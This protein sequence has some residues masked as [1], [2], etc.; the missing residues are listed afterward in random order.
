MRVDG[1]PLQH[2]VDAFTARVRA[3]QSS[4]LGAFREPPEIPESGRLAARAQARIEEAHEDVERGVV[5]ECLAR[6]RSPG[7]LRRG[8]VWFVLLWFVLLQPL[9]SGL[10]GM[11]D[12]DGTAMIPLDLGGIQRAL[13]ILVTTLGATALL[14]GLAVTLL[15]Y[16]MMLMAMFGRAARDVRRLRGGHTPQEALTLDDAEA[17][18]AYGERVHHALG[19]T[20]LAPVLEPFEALAERIEGWRDRSIGPTGARSD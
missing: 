15:V 10:L 1:V 13:A 19:D 7:P 8:L 12:V 3:R 6:R 16:V 2:R 20:V 17:A 11:I 9:L 18:Y 5:R 14:K 4:L